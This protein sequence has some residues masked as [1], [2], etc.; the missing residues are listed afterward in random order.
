MLLLPDLCSKSLFVCFLFFLIS[1]EFFFLCLLIKKLFLSF[2]LRLV[3]L[4]TVERKWNFL[5]M[6]QEDAFSLSESTVLRDFQSLCWDE[7][8]MIFDLL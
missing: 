6:G 1:L 8:R 5:S 2:G 4:T 7:G 3:S